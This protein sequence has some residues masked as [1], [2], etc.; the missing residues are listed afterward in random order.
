[1]QMSARAKQDLVRRFIVNDAAPGA[2]PL[3]LARTHRADVTKAVLVHRPPFEQQA[4][5]FDAGVRMG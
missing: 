3:H 1:M 4:Q 5:R 2:H